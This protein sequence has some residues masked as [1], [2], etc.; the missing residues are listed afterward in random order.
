MVRVVKINEASFYDLVTYNGRTSAEARTTY[1]ASCSQW[2]A[3]WQP[4]AAF[5]RPQRGLGCRCSVPLGHRN[6][7]SAVW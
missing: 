1:A 7:E 5:G 2:A 6:N 4:T 3:L